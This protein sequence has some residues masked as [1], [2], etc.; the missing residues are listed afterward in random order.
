MSIATKCP[1]CN[2]KFAAPEHAL[3]KSARCPQCGN[4]F[5]VQLAGAST[6]PVAAQPSTGGAAAAFSGPIKRGDLNTVRQHLKELKR[7]P[8]A[9]EVYRAL[10]KSALL[11][12]PATNGKELMR[13][14]QKSLKHRG[15]E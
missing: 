13:L 14:V 9:G 15:T 5:I 8:A 11:D 4:S 12:L 7:V 10:V 3:G 1:S 6:A 2:R